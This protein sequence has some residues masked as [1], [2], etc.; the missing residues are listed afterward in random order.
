MYPQAQCLA[1]GGILRLHQGLL[2]PPP[3][4]E[5][6]SELIPGLLLHFRA[7]ISACSRP[8]GFGEQWPLGNIRV[9]L[10]FPAGPPTSVPLPATTSCGQ[11]RGLESFSEAPPSLGSWAQRLLGQD[12]GRS[13]L[14]R[15]QPSDSQ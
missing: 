7:F 8:S 9:A 6:Q 15:H 11:R 4:G 14:D 10:C 2:C 13:C 1:A 3:G 12:K 5:I